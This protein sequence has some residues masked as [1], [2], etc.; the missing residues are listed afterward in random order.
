MGEK[1]SHFKK[2]CRSLMV[3]LP[4]TLVVS[5]FL[6]V[7]AIFPL[8][9]LRFRDRRIDSCTRLA[10]GI[11]NLMVHRLDGRLMEEYLEDNYELE[12]YREIHQLFHDLKMNYPDLR[13]MSVYA[14]EEGGARVI[15]DLGENALEP[16]A[17]RQL[18]EAC[19]PYLEDLMAGR[20]VPAMMEK[21]LKI[22]DVISARPVQVST[23]IGN[24]YAFAEF[25]MESA[26]LEDRQFLV[27]L[28][29]FMLILVGC[30]LLADIYLIRKKIAGPL[31]NM[32]DCTK[33]FSY[34]TESDRFQNVQN[35]E[36]LNISTHDEIEDLYYEFMSV[37]KESLYYMT[38]LNRAR[39]DIHE[40]EE[41]LDQISE[42]AFKDALTRVG[43]QA[44]YNKIS[45]GLTLDLKAGKR[46]FAIVMVDLNNLK[47][48]NDTFGHKY[49]DVYIKGCCDIIC[50]VY[51]RSPVF[52]VGGDEFIVVLRNE[53]YMSRLLRMTQI[54]EAFMAAHAKEDKEPWERFSASVGMAECMPEDESVDQVMKRADKA[55]YESKMKFKTKYGSYR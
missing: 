39:N 8:I 34:E 30:I 46:N 15:F 48:V 51:K 18:P 43:N 35:M 52:R 44:A 28:L 7:I 1:L 26:H 45:D 14:M 23:K 11:T 47:Y 49:G 12:E 24:C 25:S 27:S 4:F 19:K 10:E 3:R 40:R 2:K 5:G 6:I 21:G 54:T 53:D 16:G 55:M 13:R 22:Q 9:C 36:E 31:R 41:K 37:M 33:G 38:N 42:T 20:A 29:G 17:L 32:A 50:K